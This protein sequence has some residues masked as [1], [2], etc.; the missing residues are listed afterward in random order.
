[1]V[2][3]VVE[4]IQKA[5]GTG[6]GRLFD[7]MRFTKGSIR[8]GQEDEEAQYLDWRRIVSVKGEAGDQQ[9]KLE[10]ANGSCIP[11]S[12]EPRWL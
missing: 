4:S 2:P 9:V 6:P 1:M 3:M 11:G 7:P 8:W 12:D 10:I 5:G